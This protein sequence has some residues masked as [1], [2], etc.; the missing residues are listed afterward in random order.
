MRKILFVVLAGILSPCFSQ[1]SKADS[2]LQAIYEKSQSV[3]MV[4]GFS[5]GEKKWISSVGYADVELKAAMGVH[6]KVRTASVSKMITA[7]AIM[8]LVEKEQIQLND[9]VM[10]HITNLPSHLSEITIRQLLNHSSGIRAYKSSRERENRKEYR[11]L[12]DAAAIFHDDKLEADPGTSFQ[13]TTYGYV[14]LGLV[15]ERVSGISY[16]EHINKHIFLPSGMKASGVERF[17]RIPE[18][19]SEVYHKNSKGKVRSGE[20][21]NLSD[22]IPGGGIYSTVGDMLLF[23][24]AL[25][26]G[27]LISTASFDAMMMDSGLKKEG[28]PYG[29]GLYLYGENPKYGNV[30]G[31]SGTQMGASVQIMLLPEIKAVT[32]V[33]S[34]TSRVWEDVFYLN[35]L[36]FQLANEL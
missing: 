35:V 1:Q 31:H 25:L 17:D 8:Q 23:G 33:A 27:K 14:L 3:G 2:L 32:F 26:D 19:L 24:N 6:T 12:E 10:M 30:V 29:L 4:A 15:I 36:F 21:T 34:N 28:N 16:E 13:Y 11:M 5:S 7:V 18:N 22:R 20:R 9:K